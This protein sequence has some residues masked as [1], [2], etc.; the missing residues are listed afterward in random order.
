[1]GIWGPIFTES[2]WN[3]ESEMVHTYTLLDIAFVDGQFHLANIANQGVLLWWSHLMKCFTPNF[4]L[5]SAPFRQS[6]LAQQ[7]FS[8]FHRTFR[9]TFIQLK[10][11][12]RKQTE[13][14]Q[15]N[16]H[17]SEFST[18]APASFSKVTKQYLSV[19]PISSLRKCMQ[20]FWRKMEQVSDKYWMRKT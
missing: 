12:R 8:F 19:K 1:M 14:R 15:S 13:I 9:P 10:N 2:L 5:P 11:N 16:S 6:S 3:H 20:S 7:P 4:D 17:R 18:K